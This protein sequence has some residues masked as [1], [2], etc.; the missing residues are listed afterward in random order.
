MHDAQPNMAHALDAGFR[1]G[2]IRAILARASDA[3][4]SATMKALVIACVILQAFLST[5]APHDQPAQVP[6]TCPFRHTDL[7]RVPIMYGLLGTDADLQRR[8]DNLEVWPGGC[9]L[10]DEKEKLVCKTC[11]YCFEP[12]FGYWS[13]HISDPKLLRMK[14][15]PFIADWPVGEKQ[16]NRA[17]FYQHVRNR[18]VC[19][20]EFY[21]WY[22]L[23]EKETEDLVGKLL[24]RFDFKFDS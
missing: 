19:G 3:Q 20:E 16:T 6:T 15:D 11:R 5:A 21:C 1:F 17:N 13:K 22:K 24:A 8:I 7:K 9:V 14:V 10:G 4:R 2:F 18:D 23:S 12:L